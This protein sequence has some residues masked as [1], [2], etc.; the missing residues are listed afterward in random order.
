MHDIVTV[1]V[2]DSL[3]Q[4]SENPSNLPHTDF[5]FPIKLQ[6]TSM[7]STLKHHH[8][9]QLRVISLVIGRTHTIKMHVL[10]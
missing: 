1:K 7:L 5:I 9:S 10:F 8:T 4:L 6:K 2:A 3:S